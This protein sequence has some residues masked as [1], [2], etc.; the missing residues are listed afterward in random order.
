MI[1]VEGHKP[2]LIGWGLSCMLWSFLASYLAQDQSYLET[3]IS[4]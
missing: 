3:L 1:D 4:R 2:T